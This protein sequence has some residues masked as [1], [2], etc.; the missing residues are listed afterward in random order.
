MNRGVRPDSLLRRVQERWLKRA[1]KRFNG[2]KTQAAKW[3]GISLR[4]FRNWEVGFQIRPLQA[5]TREDLLKR[6]R[7]KK[8]QA[9]LAQFNLT[10]EDI[11][12][13][14]ATMEL[15]KI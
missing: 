13:R 4:S 14:P 12:A 9:R 15:E 7:E 2:N 5:P 6:E 8:R 3:L 1:L 11:E 10:R